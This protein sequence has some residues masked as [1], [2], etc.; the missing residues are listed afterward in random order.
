MSA[1]YW[2][3]AVY[4]I[5]KCGWVLSMVDRPLKPMSA[6]EA[7]VHVAASGLTAFLLL[8]VVV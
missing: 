8:R 2:V 3:T 6:G 7:L 1:L 4:I 5:V